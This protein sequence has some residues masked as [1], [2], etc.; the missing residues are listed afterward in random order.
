VKAKEGIRFPRTGVTGCCE[1]L[2]TKLRCFG[3]GGNAC[4]HRA[5]SLAP[6]IL[7]LVGIMNHN[8]CFPMDT[9]I[10]FWGSC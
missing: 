6:V 10:A 8:D 7:L 1:L 2:E 3:M 4:D 5:F 9:S